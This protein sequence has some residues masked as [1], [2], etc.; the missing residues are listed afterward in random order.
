MVFNSPMDVINMVRGKTN[1]QQIVMNMLKEVPVNNPIMAN[2][3]T[4]ANKGD[5]QGIT[6]IAKNIV[7]EQG[8]D[9]DKEFSNFRKQYGL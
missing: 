1:P 3:L 8:K 5:Y 6:D 9:F 4:L 7:K 2:V